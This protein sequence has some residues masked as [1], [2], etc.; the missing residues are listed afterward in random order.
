LDKQT[1]RKRGMVPFHFNIRYLEIGDGVERYR[2]LEEIP[3]LANGGQH[4]V[5]LPDF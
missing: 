5:M 1:D 2:T 3:D 4:G